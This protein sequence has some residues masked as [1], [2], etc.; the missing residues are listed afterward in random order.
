M[1][2]FPSFA[3]KGGLGSGLRRVGRSRGAPLPNPPPQ[4][5]GGREGGVLPVTRRSLALFGKC[6]DNNCRRNAFS[7]APMPNSRLLARSLRRNAP[8][9]ERLLWARVR[10]NSVEGFYFRRQ[11]PLCGYIVDFVCF[12]ARLVVEVDGATHSSPRDLAADDRRDAAL[13]RNGFVVL[14]VTNDDVCNNLEGALATIRLKLP[15]M[16]PKDAGQ[17]QKAPPIPS[18]L[19]GEG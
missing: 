7:R 9:A 3:G 17:A 11:A 1:G 18:P 16:S 12:E 10:H 5:G 2:R 6:F 8:K 14:R 19:A 4:G 15:G 13:R